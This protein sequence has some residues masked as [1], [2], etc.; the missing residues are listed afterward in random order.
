MVRRHLGRADLERAA[1]LMA[2]GRLDPRITRS[3]PLSQAAEALAVVE[4]G[5][6]PGKVVIDMTLTSPAASG[7]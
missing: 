2:Q 7:N 1:A 4:N 5:H 6:A 3:Y